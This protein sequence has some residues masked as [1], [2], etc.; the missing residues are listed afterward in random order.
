VDSNAGQVDGTP[1]NLDGSLSVSEAAAHFSVSERT[2]RRRIKDGSLTASKL[3][4]TQ[5]YEW[6]VY[7]DGAS[8]QIDSVSTRHPVNLDGSNVHLPGTSSP[9]AEQVDPIIA[10]ALDLIERMHEDQT[11]ELER[12][13]RA[14]QQLAGQLGF[15]QSEL[16]QRDR[17]IA[18]LTAPK[19][20][21]EPTDVTPQEAPTQADTGPDWQAIAQALE[22]RVKRLEEPPIEPDASAAPEPVRPWWRRL[23]SG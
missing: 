11:E 6:R 3:P 23:W 5:G 18:L 22:E 13:R 15:L 19:E 14:N 12:L 21:P 10:R 16:Q 17:Q 9:H 20:E 1:V 7:L 2:I 4:T 8:D